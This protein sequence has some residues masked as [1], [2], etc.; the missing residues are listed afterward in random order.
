M[1]RKQ[2]LAS[3]NETGCPEEGTSGEQSPCDE[4]QSCHLRHVIESTRTLT[5]QNKI[6]W[7]YCRKH[8]TSWTEK[9]CKDGFALWSQCSHSLVV[10]DNVWSPDE[11]RGDSDGGDI[12]I[13]LGVPAQLVVVP[14]LPKMRWLQ[15]WESSAEKLERNMEKHI[16]GG[17]HL[18]HPHIRGHHLIFLI[19]K[20]KI[21]YWLQKQIKRPKEPS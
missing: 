6:E 17:T 11:L 15:S 3:P 13:F 14:L 20:C 9:I 12:F 1:K 16:F 10:K 8:L 7:N 5:T 19:L 21:R 4:C 18:L 2:Y